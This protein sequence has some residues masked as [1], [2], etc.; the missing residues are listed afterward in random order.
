MLSIFDLSDI[1]Y[2]Q[3]NPKEE[4]KLQLTFVMNE[5]FVGD[6]HKSTGF[7][8][9]HDRVI[10]EVLFTKGKIQRLTEQFTRHGIHQRA[11]YIKTEAEAM[12]DEKLL[13]A[14]G[15][16]LGQWNR[17]YWTALATSFLIGVVTLMLFS[18]YQE[19]YSASS[20]F[21]LPFTPKLIFGGLFF[22]M[23]G[24]ISFAG[25]AFYN[26]AYRFNPLYNLWC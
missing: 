21:D 5:D 18:H 23:I 20:Y 24:V 16:K 2:Y 14:T 9:V 17:W 6:F 7:G 19:Q 11:G 8:Y 13:K 1:D 15:A 3:L 12:S 4:D 26:T 25:Y 10:V 22:L